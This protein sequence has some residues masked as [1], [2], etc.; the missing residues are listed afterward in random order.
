MSTQIQNIGKFE[1]IKEL[2]R[3]AMGVVY[4]GHDPF[5]NRSVAIKVA[6]AE[7]L[8]DEQQGA[9]FRKM[10]FNEAKIAGRLKH[11][12]IIHVHDAGVEEENSYIVMEYIAGN[13]S[14]YD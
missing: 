8:N 4:L 13:R 7:G 3:G 1:I 12:N 2:G 14:L 5:S 6:H 9:R 11:A 10:F